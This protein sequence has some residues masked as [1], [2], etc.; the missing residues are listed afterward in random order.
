MFLSLGYDI[1]YAYELSNN[2]N[3]TKAKIVNFNSLSQARH[4]IVYEYEVNGEIYKK[5]TSVSYFKCID[6]VNKK[7][8]CVGLEFNLIY[9][10]SNPNINDIMLGKY[11]KYKL[12]G[13][14]NSLYQFFK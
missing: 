12:K 2:Y 3:L 7:E 14:R 1:F 10:I 6:K 9:S 8:G 5:S 13:I 4:Q 11:E